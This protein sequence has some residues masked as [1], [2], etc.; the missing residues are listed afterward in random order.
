MHYLE[1]ISTDLRNSIRA[2]EGL[3]WVNCER[4]CTG[5]CF[6][7]GEEPGGFL[8]RG[9]GPFCRQLPNGKRKC[10]CAK[11]SVYEHLGIPP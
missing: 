10:D 3:K 1:R 7:A 5:A 2:Y 8:N 6:E 9:F 11:R 4:I